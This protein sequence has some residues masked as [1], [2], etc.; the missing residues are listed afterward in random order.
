[1]NAFSVIFMDTS[2][3]FSNTLL[4]SLSPRRLRS[5]PVGL[6]REGLWNRLP[7][8]R[9]PHF[10]LFLY[11]VN[12]RFQGGDG[13]FLVPFD[14]PLAALVPCK[15]PVEPPELDLI[16]KPPEPGGSLP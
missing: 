6:R 13:L 16:E 15:R 8:Q 9:R 14:L 4:N 2:S 5:V 10:S 11:R 3:Y 1:M 7:E 12:F